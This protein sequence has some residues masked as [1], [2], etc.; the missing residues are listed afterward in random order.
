MG[1]RNI[2]FRNI[3]F[4]DERGIALPLALAVLAV[5]AL[6]AVAAAAAAVTASHQS[7]R[8]RNAKRGFQAAAAGVQTAN[9]RTTLLQPGPQQCVIKD[10]S[11]GDL[12]VGP[13]QA[14]GWCAPQ[15][16]TLDDGATYT[17]QVS[18][19]TQV[20]ANGQQLVQREIVSTGLVN[21]VTRRVD[22]RTSAATTAPLFPLNYAAISLASVSYGSTVTINGGLGSNGD[23]NLSNQA[24]VCGDAT[25]GPGDQVTTANQAH[26]CDGYSTQP[27]TQPFTLDPVDQGQAPT[28]NSNAR[29]ASALAGTG[30]G[31]SCTTCGKVGWNPNTRVLSLTNNAT[32]TLGGN[33]YS[34]CR[35]DL[36]NSAQLKI[37]VNATVKIYI[38]SP[39][40]C[41]GTSG[42]GSV[43][44]QNSSGIL[45]LNSDPTTLQLYM[46]GSPSIPTTV[47]FANS[48][49][50]SMLMGIYAPYSTVYL[51]NTVSITG[52]VAGASVPIENSSS[53]TYDAR[54]GNITGGGI[55]VYRSTGKWVECSSTPPN[56]AVNS[57]C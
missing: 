36:K 41:G 55:P 9:Y 8:D 57:G 27:A 14:D 48:F 49:A 6:L 28:Q 16:E 26:V 39:E 29:I 21:G 54:V 32:L 33:T 3:R 1:F 45:N 53:I 52:A 23:I 5:V 4:R 10:P 22:V 2:R 17:Q 12:S 37:A 34:F 56:A 18:A 25:P 13:V 30:G 38:D 31:D 51:H 7:L 40:H 15:T 50:S 24:T 11:T 47:D 42:M 35:V 19:G 20:V 46:V 43:L 44:L